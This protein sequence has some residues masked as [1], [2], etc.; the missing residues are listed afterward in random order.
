MKHSVRPKPAPFVRSR[1]KARR[2]DL[3]I[4]FFDLSTPVS[5]PDSK[6]R[7]ANNTMNSKKTA[8]DVPELMELGKADNL[9]LGGSPC[10][11]IDACECTRCPPPNDQR[12]D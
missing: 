11:D 12:G 5:E 7:K 2:V 9:T 4:M 1:S 8:Y 6:L 3:Q 10:A